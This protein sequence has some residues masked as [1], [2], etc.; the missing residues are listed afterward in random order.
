MRR[1]AIRYHGGKFRIASWIVSQMPAHD[2]YIEPFGGGAN[3][4]LQKP[5]TR[6]E[7]YN[8]LDSNIVNVFRC[9]RDP[10]K[11]EELRKRCALTPF[12]RDE[13]EFSYEPPIDDIDLAHKTLIRA[14]FGFGGDAVTR[15]CRTGF[16]SAMS[17]QRQMP[18]ASWANWPDA[19]PDFVERLRGVVIENDDAMKLLERFD[20]EQFVRVAVRALRPALKRRPGRMHVRRV[21]IEQRP[22]TDDDHRELAR[23]VRELRGM[24]MISGY[25]CPLYD[26]L[27]GDWQSLSKRS[28]TES[29]K[30]RTEVLWFSPNC[31]ANSNG[32]LFA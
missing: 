18:A 10:L 6:S 30:I 8:D 15:T 26:E 29:A 13:F 4:L 32:H 27:Y 2:V 20:G 24:V 17:T 28:R 16:R 19:I 11:A 12:A 3:V 23:R 14:F 25:R 5:R 7:V 21:E 9:L 22:L 31:G 1:P